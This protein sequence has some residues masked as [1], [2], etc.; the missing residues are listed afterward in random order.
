MGGQDGGPHVHDPVHGLQGHGVHPPPPGV[1]DGEP[2]L[3]PDGEGVHGRVGHTHVGA[4]KVGDWAGP[5]LQHD[6][7]LADVFLRLALVQAHGPVHLPPEAKFETH[8]GRK[9][10]VVEPEV[11]GEL[12]RGDAVHHVAVQPVRGVGYHHGGGGVVRHVAHEVPH[13]RRPHSEGLHVEGVVDEPPE[14]GDLNILLLPLIP[15]PQPLAGPLPPGP[16]PH[17]QQVPHATL[18]H[19]V[20]LGAGP[21]PGEVRAA[22]RHHTG[23]PGPARRGVRLAGA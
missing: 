20:H 2:Q 17:R 4:G 13:G 10:V 1:V 21:R 19:A 9:P 8:G 16:E 6:G 23:L 7:T 14:G 3:S 18:P 11:L 12:G 22:Q 15:K 5:G